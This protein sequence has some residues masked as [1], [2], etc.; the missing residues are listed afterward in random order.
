[1]AASK[2]ATLTLRIEP[3]I[4]EALLRAAEPQYRSL[5]NMA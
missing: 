4:K 2:T 5:A 1:M 3:E